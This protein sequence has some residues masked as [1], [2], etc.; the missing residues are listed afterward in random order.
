MAAK[1]AAAAQ[2]A[3]A[4]EPP[5]TKELSDRDR[6]KAIAAAVVH[7]DY[8]KKMAAAA[9]AA[10]KAKSAAMKKKQSVNKKEAA[11]Q[12]CQ[13]KVGMQVTAKWVDDDADAD[14][15]DCYYDGGVVSINYDNRTAHIKFDDG[16]CDDAVSWDHIRIQEDLS[17]NDG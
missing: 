14:D 3:A 15:A 4:K 12:D 1:K 7:D 8:I 17:E 10:S 13:L 2:E 5:A 11:V 16:D 6:R 9:V